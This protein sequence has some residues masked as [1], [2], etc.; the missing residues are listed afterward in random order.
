[1]LDV[2]EGERLSAAETVRR[3]LRNDILAGTFAPGEQLR[4]EELAE[5][6]GTSRIP[7][8]EALRQ[9]E[10]EGLVILLNNRGAK[11]ASYTSMEVIELM[12]IRIALECHALKLA[13]PNMIE[14]DFEEAERILVDYDEQ[15]DPEKWAEMNWKFHETLYLPCNSPKLISLI[16][17]NYGQV[18]LFV[19]TQVSRAS[20]K[21]Q[22]QEEHFA[23]LKACRAGDADTAV[24]LLEAHISNTKK[25]LSV[26]TRRSRTPMAG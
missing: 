11:V 15:N 3:L 19:R 17:A 14:A 10:A 4:Q 22:P 20:G 23:I 25:A 26:Q 13:L 8:R 21:K 1:M 7:V 12:E 2:D 9:L 24:N 18:S 16:E 5:K 6:F